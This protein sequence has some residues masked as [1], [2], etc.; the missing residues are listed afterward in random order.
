MS[1]GNPC[2]SLFYLVAYFDCHRHFLKI[3]KLSPENNSFPDMKWLTRTKK[4]PLHINSPCIVT[5]VI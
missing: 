1:K 4:P 5:L 2:D 3:D